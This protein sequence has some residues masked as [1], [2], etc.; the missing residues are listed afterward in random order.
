MPGPEGVWRGGSRCRRRGA[1]HCSSG[2][3]RRF[4]PHFPSSL[5]KQ[6]GL[7]SFSQ[8]CQRGIPPHYL[9]S[10]NQASQ[11][12]FITNPC[13]ARRPVHSALN[14]ENL[15][16][17]RR[18]RHLAV[19]ILENT[20]IQPTT[21]YYHLVKRPIFRQVF[22]ASINIRV[23]CDAYC[24]KTSSSLSCQSEH[25]NGPECAER[26]PIGHLC[27]TIHTTQLLDTPEQLLSLLPSV[28]TDERRCRHS[29]DLPT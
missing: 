28:L 18:S 15:W 3:H 24:R 20:D 11:N 26:R 12:P 2:C 22:H 13:L 5:P 17:R 10:P 9:I 8:R 29:I 16:R 7:R 1:S 6:E 21:T 14:N 19:N 27:W 4:D 25:T 23:S